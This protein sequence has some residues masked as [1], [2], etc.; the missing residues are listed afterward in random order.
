MQGEKRFLILF[1]KFFPDPFILAFFLSLLALVCSAFFGFED[2]QSKHIGERF[3]LAGLAWA[4]GMWKF[5]AFGMQMSLIVL[6]GFVLAQAPLVT[7]AINRLASLP[8][9][10]RHAI[11]L[12]AFMACFSALI[13]WGLGLIVGA[14]LAKKMATNLEE[15]NIK[16]HYPLL[17]AAGYSSLLVWH[18]G[19]TGSAPLKASNM[20]N[21]PY[22]FKGVTVPLSETTF[23][24]L[25]GVIAFLSLI[26]I[27]L[28]FARM[29]PNTEQVKSIGDYNNLEIEKSIVQVKINSNGGGLE[30]SR[31]LPILF[32]GFLLFCI[33]L[34]MEKQAHDNGGFLRIDWL[35]AINALFFA[36]AVLSHPTLRQFLNIT[37]S[38]VKGVVGIM[39]QFPLYAGTAGVFAASGLSA[40]ISNWIV[41]LPGAE[42]LLPVYSFFAAGFINFFVPSGGGQFIIQ[43]PILFEAQ[44]IINSGAANYNPGTWLLA[45]SYGDQWTNMLQPFWAIPLLAITGVKARE[46][47]GYTTLVMLYVLPLYLLPLYFFG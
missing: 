17:A 33:F 16:V 15:R 6:F 40:I 45:L 32:S 23:S 28:F 7:Q 44:Q 46:M 10:P 3:R 4:T 21:L 29:H 2:V 13:H 43:S 22:F 25:N 30:S 42:N 41:N 5:L 47:M 26:I 1:E 12:T 38:A 8:Q 9:K 18:G 35:N 19:L 20:E 37:T 31:Y 27:P 24:E 11:W 14:L 36:L 39:I 34:W